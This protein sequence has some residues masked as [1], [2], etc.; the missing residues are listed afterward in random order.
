MKII[1]TY[2]III[3]RKQNYAYQKLIT[4]NKKST[5]YYGYVCDLVFS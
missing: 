5:A 2:Y 1:A 3:P 4:I